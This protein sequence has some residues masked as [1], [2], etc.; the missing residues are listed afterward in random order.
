MMRRILLLITII[1]LALVGYAQTPV[2]EDVEPGRFDQGKMWTFENPPVEYF[3]EAYNFEATEEWMDD[4]RKS[5]L[6]FA[7]WCSGSFISENG[8]I[9]TNHHCSRNVAISVMKDGENFNENSFYATT[10][11]EER[12]VQDLYVDQMV[13]VADVTEQVQSMNNVSPDSALKVIVAELKSTEKWKDLRTETRTFYSGGK[14]SVY[15]FK[16]YNDIRLVLYPEMALGHFGG[17]PDNFTYP[18]YSLDFTLWR[19]YDENGEPVK[20][21]NYFEFNASGADEG[22]LVFVIGNPGSTGRYLTLAQLSYMRDISIPAILT[23]YRNRIEVLKDEL[24]HVTNIQRKDSIGN[25]I[26]G[27]SNTNKAYTGILN[28]LNNPLLMTKKVKKEK[29]ARA[30]VII[31]GEDP[32]KEIEKNYQES[33]K[34]FTESFVLS[35]QGTRGKVNQ[36]VFQ[37]YDYYQFI[38]KEDEDGAKKVE[39]KM[40]KTLS[41][42]DP[43]LEKTLYSLLLEEIIEHSQQDYINGLLGGRTPLEKTNELFETSLLFTDQEKFFKLKVKKLEKEPLL[44]FST[45][46]VPKYKEANIKR[47]EISGI[48]KKYEEKIMNLQYGLTG[49]SSPPDATFSLR[50]ADGVVKGYEY[51]GT[52]APSFTTYY[53][54]YNRHFSNNQKYPW[55]LPEKWNNPPVELLQAPLNF[56]CTADVIGGNSGSPVINA[57]QEVVGLVFDGN[58]ESLP[59]YFIY[60][61]T[62]N[63]TVSVHAGGIAAALKYIYKADRIVKELE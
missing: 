41:S 43:Q 50:I 11:E 59:G 55:H 12:R 63:R 23:L 3:K 32:W 10:Q 31:E 61:V 60:D 27:L 54:L 52:E 35:Q 24:K 7:S 53:G 18:R 9:L 57:K 14:Y 28:G 1:S 17:D 2:L 8:L 37:L 33:S 48:N 51:N 15:G 26:L 42:F 5:S 13:M 49:L 4:A 25:L 40:I 21:T 20:P 22:E 56:V 58:I 36:L 30:N 6:R 38:K 19:A 47:K 16:R 39:E 45:T 62:Y 44:T 34:Y 46:M 29:Q